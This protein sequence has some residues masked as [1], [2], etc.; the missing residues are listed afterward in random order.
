[1]ALTDIG[2]LIF[3]PTLVSELSEVAPE[4]KSDVINLDAS[5]APQDLITVTINVAVASTLLA[6]TP[7]HHRDSSRYLLL[8]SA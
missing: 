1:M 2:Q 4:C 5:T 8:R 3:L 7:P 6:G